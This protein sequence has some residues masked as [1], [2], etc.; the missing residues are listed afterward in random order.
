MFVLAFDILCSLYKLIK[1]NHVFFCFSALDEY[2]VARLGV[3]R[4]GLSLRGPHEQIR[5][6]DTILLHPSYKDSGFLNDLA[7]LRTKTPLTLT[8]YVRPICL[9]P[10]D[11]SPPHASLCTVVGWGQLFEMGR[12]FRKFTL[13][14]VACLSTISLL[15]LL[16]TCIFVEF[17]LFYIF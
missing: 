10:P 2:W 6:I 4:R 8:S 16:L 9:P 17:Y 13:A 1:F 7:I 12:V 15:L 5:P 11:S 14:V 3:L